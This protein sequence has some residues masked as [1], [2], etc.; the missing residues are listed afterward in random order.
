MAAPP[1]LSVYSI[2]FKHSDALGICPISLLPFPLQLLQASSGRTAR[3][4]EHSSCSWLLTRLPST[5]PVSNTVPETLG[6]R[7]QES[8]SPHC[9]CQRRACCTQRHGVLGKEVSRERKHTRCRS[10]Q[11][12]VSQPLPPDPPLKLYHSFHSRRHK[13]PSD[14]FLCSLYLSPCIR[15]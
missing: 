3:K 7:K 2:A 1:L 13:G 8:I 12:S 11:P 4:P 14:F 6:A 9:L 5:R 10:T 15:S